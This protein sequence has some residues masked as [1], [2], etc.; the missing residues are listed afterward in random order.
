MLAAVARLQFLETFAEENWSTEESQYL[1]P[2]LMFTTPASGPKFLIHRMVGKSA[3]F[4]RFWSEWTLQRICVEMNR[5][6][7]EIHPRTCMPLGGRKWWPLERIELKAFIVVN[8]LMGVKKLPNH[9][10]Y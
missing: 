6:A 5:Y 3:L 2:F 8:L 4:A 7:N 1:E 10:C 9:R